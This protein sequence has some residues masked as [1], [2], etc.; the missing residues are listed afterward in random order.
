M[1]PEL[2]GSPRGQ[3]PP[4]MGSGSIFMQ[5]I[6]ILPLAEMEPEADPLLREGGKRG[7]Q[8]GEG[9][10]EVAWMVAMGFCAAGKK[11]VGSGC[12]DPVS[13]T[14]LEIFL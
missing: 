8:G 10:K 6:K 1:V 4:R 13:Y 12:V 7:A 5:S 3:G 9:W 2:Q 14:H 11:A